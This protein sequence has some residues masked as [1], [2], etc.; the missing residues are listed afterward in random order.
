MTTSVLTATN[1]PFPMANTTVGKSKYDA[2]NNDNWAE[3]LL[4]LRE[5][6]PKKKN[7]S[8]NPVGLD[9]LA[10]LCSSAA[11]IDDPD[12]ASHEKDK[13]VTKLVRRQRS[14]SNPE[15]ME[16]WDAIGRLE[17]RESSRTF[18]PPSSIMEEEEGDTDNMAEVANS[19]SLLAK[20]RITSDAFHRQQSEEN[21]SSTVILVTSDDNTDD[22]SELLRQARMKLLE[23]MHESGSNS[24]GNIILPHSLTKY[25]E[26]YNKNGRIGIYTPAE[27]AAIISRF[28]SKRSRRVWNKKIRYNCR[29]NLADRRMRVKGRFVKRSS[30]EAATALAQVA[31]TTL[32]TVEE[33]SVSVTPPPS[34]PPT[35]QLAQQEMQVDE[36]LPDVN[37]EEAGFEPTLDQ[38]FRRAR[39]HTI[40]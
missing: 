4:K 19:L 15:G 18:T 5:S 28:H 26:L 12:N 40:T 22:P 7:T 33:R 16:K 29:K 36:N 37:D 8:F 20:D 9:A 11:S 6:A 1:E 14:A 17:Q 38:P 31:T 24:K 27:R 21:N 13:N 30:E 25:R 32:E 10:V 35:A 39:R 34:P 23:D 2:S 3:A